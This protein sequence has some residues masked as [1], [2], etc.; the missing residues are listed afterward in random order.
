VVKAGYRTFATGKWHNGVDAFNRCYE[1]GRNVFFG[2]M[3]NH[4]NVPVTDRTDRE[5]Y[6]ERPRRFVP[7]DG[8]AIRTTEGPYDRC[9]SWTHS[10]DLFSRT[11]CKFIRNH[12]VSDDDRPFFDYLAFMAPHDPRTAP[13]AYHAMY[14]PDDIDL[15]DNFRPA[16]PFDNGELH[17][18]DEDLAEHPRE[19]AEIRRHIADY[20]AM[21]SPTSIA[22]S[23]ASSTRSNRLGLERTR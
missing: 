1:A 14:D 15:P 9:S 21:G 20:Y 19:G 7:G 10:S 18:R 11:M 3:G 5:E 16:H 4:W 23:G 8:S 12:A 2:G 13:G 17:V 6:T 22:G